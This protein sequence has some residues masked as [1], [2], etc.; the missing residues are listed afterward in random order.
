MDNRYIRPLDY[1]LP[2]GPLTDFVRANGLNE[3]DIAADFPLI[4]ESGEL[5]VTEFEFEHLPGGG[6][7]KVLRDGGDE[8][9]KHLR[10]VPLKSPPEAHG[11]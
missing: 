6:R 1:R 9:V 4:I 10:T 3:K 8:V 11:L 7:R 5:T 2:H